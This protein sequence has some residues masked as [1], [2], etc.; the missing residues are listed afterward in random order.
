MSAGPFDVIYVK[1]V[2][3]IS[4]RNLRVIFGVNRILELV[5]SCIANRIWT[6]NKQQVFSLY[7]PSEGIE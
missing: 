1:L 2:K 4:P 5:P 7:E 3:I 6:T